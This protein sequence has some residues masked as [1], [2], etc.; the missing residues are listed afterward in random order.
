M[1]KLPSDDIL[2]SLHKLRI[3]DSAQLKTVLELYDMEIYQKISMPNYQKMK[4][5]VRKD[6]KLRLRNFDCRHEKIETG[7][8]VKSRKGLTDVEGGK[9]FCSK[10]KEKGQCSKGKQ[11]SFWHESNDRAKKTRPQ[12]RHTFRTILVTSVSKKRSIQGKSNPGT[13]LRQLCRCY[14]KGTCTRSP[15]DYWHPPECY[16]YKKKKKRDAKQGDKCL[17]PHYKVDEQPSKKSKKSFNPQKRT[18]GR[19]GCC[20]YCENCTTVG[21]CFARLRAIRTSESVKYRGNPRHEVWRSIRRVRFTQSSPRQASIRENNGPSLGKIQVK[22]PHQR[23][24]PTL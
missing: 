15:S 13:I 21:L 17:F 22:I 24:L 10:W 19:E 6:Q 8:V 7:A 18:K 4:T 2:E 23:A 1:S 12:C 20:S 5:M 14:L 9:G 16:F 11:C 3:R